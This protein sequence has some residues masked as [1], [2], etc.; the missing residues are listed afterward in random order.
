MST[1]N[2]VEYKPLQTYNRCVMFFNLV[3][4]AGMEGAKEYI[5]QFSDK[6]KAAMLETY[7]AVKALGVEK[8]KKRIMRDMPLQEDEGDQQ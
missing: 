7:K 8:V 4:D 5:N 6:D 2:D 1:F 3:E